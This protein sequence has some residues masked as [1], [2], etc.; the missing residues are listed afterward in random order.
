MTRCGGIFGRMNAARLLTALVG[1]A[2]D[3]ERV[4]QLPVATQ[5]SVAAHEEGAIP[6]QPSPDSWDGSWPWSDGLPATRTCSEA[7]QLQGLKE[8]TR[9]AAACVGGSGGNLEAII[10]VKPGGTVRR[11]LLRGQRTDAQGRC[12]AAAFEGL[13]FECARGSGF[14]RTVRISP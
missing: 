11:V 13:F 8:A 9:V 7:E 2:C 14:A 3:S 12:V 5:P 10:L 4:E 1:I 6:E